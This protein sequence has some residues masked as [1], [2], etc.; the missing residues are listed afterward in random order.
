MQTTDIVQI[1][2][3]DPNPTR[4]GTVP[5]WLETAAE[6]LSPLLPKTASK[7]LL[8]GDMVGPDGKPTDVF[9]HFGV[10]PDAIGTLLG[11]YHGI[12][13]TARLVSSRESIDT[14]A[15]AWPGFEDVWIPIDASLSLA[16]RLGFSMQN[17]VVRDA[18][19]III[20]PG[21]FGDNG[22]QRS[23]DLA[24]A[25]IESG[26]HVLAVE[27]RGHGQTERKYPNVA[28]Q[29]GAAE[30]ADLLT[31]AEWAQAKPHVVS[32]GLIGFCW[33]GQTALMA[34]WQDG[35][36]E[37]DPSVSNLIAPTFPKR[38]GDRHF[39]AGVIAFSPAVKWEEILDWLDTEHTTL[40]QPIYA[41]LQDTVRSR[42]VRKNMPQPD[43]SMRRLIATEFQGSPLNTPQHLEDIYTLLRIMPYNDKFAPAKMHR[44]RVPVLIV[45]AADD[46]MIPAQWTADLA[47]MTKNPYIAFLVL[48]S[49][50]HV[51]FAAWARSYYFSLI[52][53]YFDMYR[54]AAAAVAP[55]LQIKDCDIPM[56]TARIIQ[57]N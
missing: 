44:I 12:F 3:L 13:Y 49:G 33:S 35:R 16:G 28:Y 23:R 40:K 31:V 30:S 2:P 25:L 32:T 24:N 17:G 14:A 47:A 43:G 56:P 54:G 52:I 8:T 22:V 42:M 37:I 53:N 38:T 7:P 50:G 11:N 5:E 34:A 9:K 29:F 26:Y 48:P 21:F 20:L 45:H 10:N 46:P 36:C 55:R 57:S 27:L 4:N 6:D 19:C 51:G 41:A 39:T 18:P 1:R 15:P